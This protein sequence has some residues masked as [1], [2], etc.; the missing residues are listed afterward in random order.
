MGA[1]ILSSFSLLLI[2]NLIL[3]S[4]GTILGVLLAIPFA[5]VIDIIFFN[6][7]IY[8]NVS[9]V[10][11]IDFRILTLGIAPISLLFS[12]LSGGIPAYLLAKRNIAAILKG[13]YEC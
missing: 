13:G 6:N 3:V 10:A 7:G 12:F 4:I 8:N 5:H 2:E 11:N 9:I 1:T